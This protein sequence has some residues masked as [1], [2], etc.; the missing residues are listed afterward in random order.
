MDKDIAKR[1]DTLRARALQAIKV[2]RLA[3]GENRITGMSCAPTG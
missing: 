1:G 3:Q 2:T